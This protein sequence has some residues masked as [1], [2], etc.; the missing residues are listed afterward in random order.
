M[1]LFPTSDS[2]QEVVDFAESLL[3]ITNGN[4]FYSLFMSYHNT[5]LKVRKDELIAESK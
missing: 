5:L 4:E 1:E 2:L 3:P